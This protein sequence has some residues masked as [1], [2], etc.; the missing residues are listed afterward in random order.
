MGWEGC[1]EL[2]MKR[3][4]LVVFL[5]SVAGVFFIG[6]ASI[7]QD[8]FSLKHLTPEN[9]H[10]ADAEGCS[11]CKGTENVF[12][13]RAAG[14]DLTTDPPSLEKRGWLSS[15][16]ARSQSHEDRVNT[17]CAWCHAPLAE[18]A[19]KDKE[20]AKPI[21]KGTWQGVTCGACHPGSVPREKRVSL[22]SNFTPGTDRT[23]PKNYVFRDRSKGT[24]MN[25]QC[26]FCHEQYHGLL[27]E[28]KKKMLQSGDLRC[29]D[30][31]MAAYA[32]TN[33]H[34]ERYHNFKVAENI[35]HSCS[36]GMGRASSCHDGVKKEWFEGKLNKV[37]GP[38]K[39][40]SL[41][42]YSLNK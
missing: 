29:I 28:T 7:R 33:Q 41:E 40:W 8:E 30:C 5:F 25:A 39:E 3:F 1:E 24:D 22:V 15:V 4:T 31:H 14:V 21:P 34:V 42:P 6:S 20:K 26:Q 37:K 2:I 23:N 35:P 18:G 17:A 38:R 16:H 13:P 36:G 12:M 9:Y 32:V 11:N 10:Y 27:I 19:T